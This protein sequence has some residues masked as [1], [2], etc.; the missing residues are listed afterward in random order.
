METLTSMAWVASTFRNQGRWAEAEKLDVQVMEIRKIVLRPEAEHP[1]TLTTTGNL[2]YTYQ[3]QG[4]WTEGRK[5]EAQV[6]ETSKTVLGP[7]H[8][9]G[10]QTPRSACGAYPIPGKSWA[11]IGMLWLCWKPASSF[12]INS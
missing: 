3:Y 6:M 4:R 1:S 5:L 12:K 9:D 10:L 7:K 8:P 11:E 2:A